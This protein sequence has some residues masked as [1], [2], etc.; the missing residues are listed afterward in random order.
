MGSSHFSKVG[1]NH[2]F[3]E[4]SANGKSGG[5]TPEA[6]NQH[7]IPITS[8]TATVFRVLTDRLRIIAIIRI[9]ALA[10]T[11]S[12]VL[13]VRTKGKANAIRRVLHFSLHFCAFARSKLVYLE[14]DSFPFSL[15]YYIKNFD[16]FQSDA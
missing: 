7:D 12:I 13:R 2:F 5:V 16:I 6:F 15:L 4:L 9:L 14:K 3:V 1:S 8:I 11:A 10:D